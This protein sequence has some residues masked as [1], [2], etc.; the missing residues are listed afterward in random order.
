MAAVVAADPRMVEMAATV[1]SV[2]AA[3]LAGLVY[4]V[5]L[6]A[7]MEVSEVAVEERQTEALLDRRTPEMAECSEETRIHALA[8]VAQVWAAAGRSI[9][10]PQ[11]PPP[12]QGSTILLSTCAIR[13][14]EPARRDA[15]PGSPQAARRESGRR[16]RWLSRRGNS[17]GWKAPARG[18]P[19]WNARRACQRGQ[20]R[21]IPGLRQ[22]SVIF[23]ISAAKCTGWSRNQSAIPSQTP[24][25]G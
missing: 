22:D 5:A 11:A 7:A 3:V 12:V 14:G 16:Q 4:W 13:W 23:G 10:P 19:G 17:Y 1:A 9:A 25:T 8:A 2:A 6:T 20:A 24:V 15:C 18:R 21:S